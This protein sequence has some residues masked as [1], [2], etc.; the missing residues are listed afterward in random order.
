M[1]E[2][3]D[4]RTFLTNAA[5]LGVLVP[6]S[7]GLAVL[8]SGCG[9]GA[10]PRAAGQPASGAALSQTYTTALGFLPSFLETFVAK[11]RGFWRDRGLQVDI[12]GGQG[13]ASAIQSVIGGSSAYSRASGINSI[14][15]VADQQAP[16]INVGTVYQRSQFVLASLADKAVTDPKQLAGK[17]V[18]VVSSGGSTENLLDVMLTGAGVAKDKVRRPVT[19]VG[20][21]AYQLAKDGRVDAWIALDGDIK[22]LQEQQGA[23]ITTVNTDVYAPIPADSY[24][25]SRSVLTSM[26]D[27]VP[28]FLAGVLDA[29]RFTMDKKNWDAVVR[30]IQVYNPELKKDVA[31]FQIPLEV[32]KW[33]AS[34]PDRLL[35]MDPAKWAKGAEALKKAGLVTN[36]VPTERLVEPGPLDKARTS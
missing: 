18:G 13:T 17:S 10:K 16:I 28:R 35:A 23:Q 30:A 12:R 9:E 7:G 22:Q 19:G 36:A 26:P 5:R 31:L 25:V 2:R 3:Y 27:A 29:M 8:L 15:A 14:I 34:G 32:E 6:A 24:V 1:G 4:R 33:T 20:A 11:E 21:A